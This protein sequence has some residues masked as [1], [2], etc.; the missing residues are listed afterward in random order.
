MKN[1]LATLTIGLSG[2]VLFSACAPDQY[3]QQSETDDLYFTA[4]DRN[5]VDVVKLNDPSKATYDNNGSYVYQEEVASKNFNP[6][7]VDVEKYQSNQDNEIAD[8]DYYVAEEDRDYNLP[9]NANRFNGARP[10]YASYGSPFYSGAGMWN[11]P[12]YSPY[13]GSS[14][15]YDPYYS[16]G[17]YDP[18][19]DPYYSSAFYDP[20]YGSRWYARPGFNI[21]FGLAF[22]NA[23]G[24]GRPGWG[25]R[26]GNPYYGYGGAYR[27]GFYDG[28]YASNPYY[29]YGYGGS[30]VVVVNN[31]V[32]GPRRTT[33]A[34]R[35]S[36]TSRAIQA[37]DRS[38]TRSR[39]STTRTR[40]SYTASR[41]AYN[42]A[43]KSELNRRGRASTTPASGARYRTARSTP[44][45]SNSRTYDASRVRQS[46]GSNSSVY[47]PRTRTSTAPSRA[48]QYNSNSNSNY[49]RP[50]YNGNNN[51]SR[52]DFGSSNR[53]RSSFGSSPSRSSSG[54]YSSGS[55]SRSSSPS[56]S[57]SSSGSSRGSRG[58]GRQ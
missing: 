21:S 53:S 33:N 48:R 15:F 31:D 10:S 51:R 20:F 16:R 44:A 30:T 35:G 17:F 22:G 36:R 28:F 50:S 42:T 25:N 38:V 9:Q 12:F 23:W 52:S 34:G 14:A 37:N 13:Y 18:F 5:T 27:N 46:S 1:L 32:T 40:S 57:R 29:R 49:S 39:T 8:A 26:W 43:S 58:G 55:S 54:S 3:A 19:Y 24:W 4:S 11:D 2:S 47:S 6:D 45:S 41:D 7:A 56:P